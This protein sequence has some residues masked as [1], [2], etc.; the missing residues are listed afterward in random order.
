MVENHSRKISPSAR[1]IYT[2]GMEEWKFAI[3]KWAREQ[4]DPDEQFFPGINLFA[5]TS[6]GAMKAGLESAHEM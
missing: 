2:G 3:F 6:E 4:Y 1:L 5:R